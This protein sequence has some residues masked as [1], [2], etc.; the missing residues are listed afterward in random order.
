MSD[1]GPQAPVAFEKLLFGQ[2]LSVYMKL[3]HQGMSSED[4][5]LFVGRHLAGRLGEHLNGQTI[6]QPY[7]DEFKKYILSFVEAK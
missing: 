7:G 3:D 1:E 2:F 5:S 6:G 4:F